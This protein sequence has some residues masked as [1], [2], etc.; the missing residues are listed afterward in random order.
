MVTVLQRAKLIDTAAVGLLLCIFTLVPVILMLRNG[1]DVFKPGM[2]TATIALLGIS[3]PFLISGS[4]ILSFFW[5]K[6]RSVDK[7]Y[8]STATPRQLNFV[9]G[10]SVSVLLGGILIFASQ[11]LSVVD[12][13]QRY[14]TW[15][16]VFDVIVLL[17]IGFILH[18]ILAFIL[19]VRR[20]KHS[21][22]EIVMAQRANAA[23]GRGEGV[24]ASSG[25]SQPTAV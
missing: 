9:M 15:R 17:L 16:I 24:W 25:Q 13:I 11:I 19:E 10:A 1:A 7:H 22:N 23:Q 18:S 5:Y 12:K 3:W 14:P 21:M 2:R 4:L 20:A 8:F 6:G